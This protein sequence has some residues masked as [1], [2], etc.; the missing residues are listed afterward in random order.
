MLLANHGPIISG[1]DLASAAD[2]VEDSRK[3]RASTSCSSN[4]ERGR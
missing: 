1:A 2:A 3:P 4:G